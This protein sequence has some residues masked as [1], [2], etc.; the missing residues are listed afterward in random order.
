VILVNEFKLPDAERPSGPRTGK[1]GGESAVT[2]GG[3]G[4]TLK[5]FE[6]YRPRTLGEIIKA[7]SDSETLTRSNMILTGDTFPSRVKVVHTGS[8]RQIT[9]ARKQHLEMLVTSF[10][11]DPKVISRYE[12][13]LLFVEG[14]EEHWLP[15]QKEL[16]PFFEKEL[17]KG[18]EVI[19]YAEWVGARKLGGKWEWI[20]IVNE[21]QKL[22]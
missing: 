4:D 10:G 6:R 11:V 13:E 5:G 16:I 19:L 9:P 8:T 22:R 17:K 14:T 21:F 12:K 1:A 20:F 7:H 18:E 15:V 2:E 3:G